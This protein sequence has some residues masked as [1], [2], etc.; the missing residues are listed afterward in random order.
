MKRYDAPRRRD[1]TS[2]MSPYARHGKREYQYP[3]ALIEWRN[4][5]KKGAGT[6]SLD[7]GRSR[8]QAHQQ[9]GE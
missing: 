7:G 8:A 1:R 3:S 4:R 2:G 6:L 9:A 5:I